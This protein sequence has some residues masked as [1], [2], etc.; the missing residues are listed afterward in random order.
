MSYTCYDTNISADGSA[1]LGILW[2]AIAIRCCMPE[3]TLFERS[4]H[5]I[6]SPFCS[7][8]NVTAIQST[9][10][11]NKNFV[12]P[13]R[14][15]PTETKDPLSWAWDAVIR[16]RNNHSLS[17]VRA[18][19]HLKAVSKFNLRL[20]KA[21]PPHTSTTTYCTGAMRV[22]GDQILKSTYFQYLIFGRRGLTSW[23]PI[24]M[25]RVQ[26]ASFAPIL[27]I[28]PAGQGGRCDAMVGQFAYGL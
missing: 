8:T 15:Q 22:N 27:T 24:R 21:V 23:W 6:D 9:I 25:K 18:R 20:D 5:V 1:S 14:R 13:A 28:S 2:S 3:H 16:I 10:K 12:Q 7:Q 4:F 26:N 19:V 11:F 17:T